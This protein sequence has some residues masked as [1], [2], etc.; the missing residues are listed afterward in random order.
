[1]Q[2]VYD[3]VIENISS[4]DEDSSGVI[5]KHRLVHT[6][7]DLLGEHLANLKLQKWHL[8][9]PV[10]RNLSQ[11]GS[12]EDRKVVEEFLQ[13]YTEGKSKIFYQTATLIDLNHFRCKLPV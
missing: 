10:L 6:A 12:D 9:G 7:V 8:V 11:S 2:A 4:W 3:G 5:V 1:M 13:R